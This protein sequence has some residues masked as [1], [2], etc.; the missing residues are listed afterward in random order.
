MSPRTVVGDFLCNVKALLLGRD[1]HVE[2]R[3]TD[4]VEVA[5]LG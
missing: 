5:V 1:Q 2:N 3:G 4:L